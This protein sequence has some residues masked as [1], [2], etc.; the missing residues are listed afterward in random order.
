MPKRPEAATVFQRLH[1]GSEVLILANTWDAVSAR[2][3]ADLGAKAVATSSAAVAW[4]HG[5][6]DVH[7]LPFQRLLTTVQEIARVVDAPITVDM[8]GG[9]SNDPAEVARNVAAVIEAG[10]V[11]MNLEDGPDPVD[12]CCRKIEAVRAAADAVGVD[13]FINARVDVY[14]YKVAEGDAAIA[15]SIARGKRY[16]AAGASGVFL[17]GPSDGAILKA[18]AAE[19]GAPLNAMSRAGLPNAAALQKLGVRRLSASAD[20]IHAAMAALRTQAAAWLRDGDSAPLLAAGAPNT[21]YNAIFRAAGG[22]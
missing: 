4:A 9:Y 12:L 16:I 8:E 6:A 3:T 15:E 21:N 11:G 22:G 13:F 17:P 19:V 5:Y 18:V 10:A 14:L 2:V 7:H 20:M 1:Q